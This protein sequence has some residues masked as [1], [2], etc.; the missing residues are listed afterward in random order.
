VIPVEGEAKRVK[1]PP[2]VLGG[3]NRNLNSRG[4]LAGRKGRRGLPQFDP[5]RGGKVTGFHG[6]N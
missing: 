6:K 1:I 3:I 4:E 5:K 2:G